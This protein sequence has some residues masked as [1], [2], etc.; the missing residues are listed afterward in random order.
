MSVFPDIDRQLK[1]LNRKMDKV[2]AKVDDDA[3]AIAANTKTISAMA[4]TLTTLVEGHATIQEELQALKD[5]NPA[6][7]F[8]AL[9][10]AIADQNAAVLKASALVPTTP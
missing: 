10:A 3:A 9:D 4:D 6:V 7:D 8:T 5:A 1:S 2:M